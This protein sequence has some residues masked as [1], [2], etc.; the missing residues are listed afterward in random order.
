MLYISPVHPFSLYR[1]TYSDAFARMIRNISSS[2]KLSRVFSILSNGLSGR[3]KQHNALKENKE[4]DEGPPSSLDLVF[5]LVRERV[6]NQH[7]RLTALDTKVNY[8]LGGAT[9]L[10][11]TALVLQSLLL[12]H[13]NSD[14]SVFIPHILYVLPLPIRRAIPLLPLLV[15]YLATVVTGVY[16]YRVRSIPRVPDPK[17]LAIFFLYQEENH[18]KKVVLRD[19]V[20]AFEQNEKLIFMKARVTNIAFILLVA[21]SFALVLLLLYQTIC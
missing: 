11:S 13:T 16:S 9:A 5:D 10:V 20:N 8:T 14:C 2:M 1:C 17:R 3:N 15:T 4:N 18:T 7:E 21:E 12:P 6:V 19:M